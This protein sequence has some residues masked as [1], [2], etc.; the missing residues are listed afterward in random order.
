MSFKTFRWLWNE[1]LNKLP[2]AMKHIAWGLSG[3]QTHSKKFG[4]TETVRTGCGL[5]GRA[6]RVRSLRQRARYLKILRVRGWRFKVCGCGA[7]ADKKF[8]PAQDSTVYTFSIS[9][10]ILMKQQWKSRS[11]PGSYRKFAPHH[12]FANLSTK[13]THRKNRWVASTAIYFLTSCN[14][15]A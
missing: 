2:L 4:T 1:P 5:G 3:F 14:T 8:Q 15:A 13:V 9:Y 6:R 11:G 7:G 12:S 10:A